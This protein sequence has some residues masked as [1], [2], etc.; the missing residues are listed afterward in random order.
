MLRR[1]IFTLCMLMTEH[2][3]ELQVAPEEIKIYMLITFCFAAGQYIQR[4][5]SRLSGAT[6]SQSNKP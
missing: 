6:R 4:M 3:S 1:S 2:D 5:T